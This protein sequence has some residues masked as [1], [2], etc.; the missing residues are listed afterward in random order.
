MLGSGRRACY[1]KGMSNYTAEDKFIRGMVILIS[2]GA[3]TGVLVLGTV[4]TVLVS[5]NFNVLNWME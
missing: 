4:V 1:D 2:T 3:V 5:S